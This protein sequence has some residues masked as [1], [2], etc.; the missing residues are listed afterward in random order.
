MFK[1]AIGIALFKLH[2]RMSIVNLKIR[3]FK[4]FAETVQMSLSNRLTGVVGPNGSGKSNLVD[5]I[6]W[7]I[8]EHMSRLLRVGSPTD[9]IFAGLGERKPL[10]MAEVAITLDNRTLKYPREEQEITIIRRIFKDG[11]NEFEI[12]GQ[13][14]RKCDI[15]DLFRGTGLGRQTYSVVGQGEVDLV[16]SATPSERLKV[17]EEL[18]G[19]DQLR[20]TKRAVE[21]KLESARSSMEKIQAHISELTYQYERLEVQEQVLQRFEHLKTRTDFL[22]NQLLLINLRA[23]LNDL[24]SVQSK[25]G[26]LEIKRK[27]AQAELDALESSND[28]TEE[29]EN[30]EQQRLDITKRRE[31]TLIAST[32][33]EAD[34]DHTRTKLEDIQES[35]RIST[36]ELE[37][38]TRKEPSISIII[39]ELKISYQ[40]KEESLKESNQKLITLEQ[41]RPGDEKSSRLR[42]QLLISLEEAKQKTDESRSR[43]NEINSKL[44]LNVERKR[45]TM[46]RI[47]E[48]ENQ[49]IE[50][51]PQ[52]SGLEGSLNDISSEKNELEQ[53]LSEV[54]EKINL[55][56]RDSSY[57]KAQETN[58]QKD[59]VKQREALEG[60]S[61]LPSSLKKPILSETLDLSKLSPEDIS[62]IHSQL[63][64]IVADNPLDVI[65]KIPKGAD[66][67]IIT[68]KTSFELADTLKD[69]I[70]SNTRLALTRDGFIKLDGGYILSSRTKITEASIKSN[71]NII[72]KELTE[73]A[74]KTKNTEQQLSEHIKQR[75]QFL[76]EM[77]KLSKDELELSSTIASMKAKSESQRNLEQSRAVELER[78]RNNHDDLEA[79]EQKNITERDEISKLL[80]ESIETVKERSTKLSNFDQDRLRVQE[81]LV[82]FE[83]T[84]GQV[85][86][87]KNRIE[88]EYEDI[89]RELDQKNTELQ[90]GRERSNNLDS[91]IKGFELSIK[92]F[93]TKII[94]GERHLNTTKMSLLRYERL[95]KEIAQKRSE[96][97]ENSEKRSNQ[98]KATR[99]KLTRVS[100]EAH[101]VEIT[102]AETK[103]KRDDLL[104]RISESGCDPNDDIES[105]DMESIKFELSNTSQKLAEYGAVNMAAKEEA[106]EAKT[107]LDFLNGQLQDLVQSDVNLRS[108]LSEVETK[109]KQTFE[110]VYRSVESHFRRLADLLFEGAI[111]NLR[112]VQD[113]HNETVGIEVE[114]ILPGRRIKSLHALSGGEKTL[115]A[116]ALLFAFFKTKSSPFCILDEVDAALDDSNI[117][118]FTRL[119][120]SEAADTQ[121]VIITHNKETMRWCDA[122]YGITLDSTGTSR[123]VSVRLDNT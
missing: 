88:K 116:M 28:G 39:E 123:V 97:Q 111:G 30:I 105:T 96:T 51:F 69:A 59:K 33:A 79:E 102:Q 95:E 15:E 113:D 1:L 92:E 89:K 14:V 53:K 112:R 50:T 29:L 58:L 84:L 68:G 70:L 83:K 107:R 65:P 27:D 25:L 49:N 72:E 35:S 109:I 98:I 44:S 91:Q 108:A 9:V 85:R 47:E 62:L 106:K 10:S 31:E 37:A 110:E 71:L 57:I 66:I 22:K 80:R 48:L 121:F 43:L 12:N 117:E 90:T 63:D 60:C 104:A 16:L 103:V 11:E 45:A 87:I 21:T 61:F 115:A 100:Q 78:F 8:G 40:N 77:K 122:L 101:E 7:G 18:A 4:T 56:Q 114:F 13:K 119:L 41:S 17:M 2:R 34:L 42:Q 67:T 94:D 23:V 120:S 36:F 26:M 81:K 5:A 118:R 20:S 74:K 93:E 75:D 73:I 86:E 76:E 6:R 55:L 54:S 64:W 24:M 38:W 46:I 82:E 19:V 99:A 32:K 52:F 3:G